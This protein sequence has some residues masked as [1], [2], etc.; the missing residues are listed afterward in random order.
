M[1]KEKD[2]TEEES[3][4]PEEEDEYERKMRK[5]FFDVLHQTIGRL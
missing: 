4:E 2:T 5:L 3:E 1:S